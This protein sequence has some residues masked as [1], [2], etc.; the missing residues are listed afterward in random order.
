MAKGSKRLSKF[1]GLL[2]VDK[3]TDMTSQDVVNVVRRVAGTRRVGHTGTLDPLATGLLL[4]L[5]GEA[6]KLSEYMVGFDKVYEG[7]LRLGVQSNTY[8]CQGEVVPGPGGAIPDEKTLHSLAQK[9]TGPIDQVPPPYSA[10]KVRGKKLYEYARAGV[11]VEA[12]AR[13]VTISEFTIDRLDGDTAHF[14]IACTSGTYVRSLVHDVGQDAGCGALV[15]TLRR[16]GVEDFHEDEAVTLDALQE[17]GEE[18]IASVL[19]PMLDAV[20]AWPIYHVQKVGIEWL[21][22]GQAIPM[23]LTQ[24]DSESIEGR[25]GDL[26]FLCP[27]GGDACAVAKIVPTPPSKPPATLSR[28]AGLWLQPVKVLGEAEG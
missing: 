25:L 10:V 23:A 20:T 9:Y 3:P 13:R 5:V 21:R 14:R 26:V 1:H 4:V 27:L 12:A 8:D 19:L 17:G 16:T 24:V 28:F 7:T 2:V 15:E 18:G 11:E 22:R 6:T